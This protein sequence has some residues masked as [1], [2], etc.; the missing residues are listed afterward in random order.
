MAV[1]PLQVH[2]PYAI[3]VYKNDV[4]VKRI[5]GYG[6]PEPPL[7]G[8]CHEWSDQSR[9]NLAFVASNTAVKFTWMVTL[10]Y[11]KY[12]PTDG[13]ICKRHLE[14][15]LQWIRDRAKSRDMPKPEHLWFFEFQKRGAPHFHILF[16]GELDKMI[17]TDNLSEKWFR[18]VM[19]LD[20]NHLKAG[21]R[22][23]RLRSSDGGK[24][25]AVK[26]AMKMNQKV[27]PEGFRNAGRF[28]GNSKGV[29][30]EPIGWAEVS[31]KADLLN[32]VE[33][34]EYSR[35]L[36]GKNLS[37]LYGASDA[38]V[39][40]IKA[41]LQDPIVNPDDTAA[42]CVTPTAGSVTHGAGH[43]EGD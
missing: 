25:Y 42:I 31:G 18:I 32:L 16:D 12:F 28:W 26:Y 3:L 15:F 23:E 40:A 13:K 9:R 7:R 41:E 10:T 2:D 36:H 37:T 5:G 43:S 35:A 24:R 6:N 27:V 39:K 22:L 33:D 19:S 4:V 20:W 30:P 38:V 11:P 8:E 34:W 1:T 14:R 21:T 29:N 17:T